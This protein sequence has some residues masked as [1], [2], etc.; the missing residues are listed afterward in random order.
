MSSAYTH[1]SI[2]LTKPSNNNFLFLHIVINNQT[3]THINPV[4][5]HKPHFIESPQ[6]THN[7]IQLC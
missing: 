4:F 6:T 2:N 3:P 5:A 7:V 1:N